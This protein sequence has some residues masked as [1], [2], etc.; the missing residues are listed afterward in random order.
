[1]NIAFLLQRTISSFLR[2]YTSQRLHA[3]DATRKVV[4]HHYNAEAVP[5]SAP[6]LRTPRLSAGYGGNVRRSWVKAKYA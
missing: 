5:W 1:M 6:T 2:L 4:D 3:G